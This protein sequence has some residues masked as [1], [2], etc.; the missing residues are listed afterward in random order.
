M[1]VFFLTSSIYEP[2]YFGVTLHI[3]LVNGNLISVPNY[4][5]SYLINKTRKELRCVHI[6]V[7]SAHNL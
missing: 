6:V 5:F 2:L 3:P 1:G 4:V 7:K